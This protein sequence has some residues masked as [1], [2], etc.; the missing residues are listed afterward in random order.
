MRDISTIFMTKE[1]QYENE[2]DLAL[3]EILFTYCK[4]FDNFIEKHWKD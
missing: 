1:M 3:S 4:P 2:K